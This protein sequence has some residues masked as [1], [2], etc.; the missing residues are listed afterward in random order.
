MSRQ[1]PPAIAACVVAVPLTGCVGT[2]DSL[3]RVE[4]EAPATGCTVSILRAGTNEVIT[5]ENVRGKF[6]FAHTAGGPFASRVDIV[7][8]CND[9]VVKEVK[10]VS[11]RDVGDVQLGRIAAP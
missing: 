7:A 6:S 10:S 1:W 3:H 8:R 11:L 5:T 9:A 2:I 4:G